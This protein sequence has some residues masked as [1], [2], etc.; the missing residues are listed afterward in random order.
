[1]VKKSI[2]FILLGFLTQFAVAETELEIGGS[3]RARW[4]FKDNI[5]DSNKNT[6]DRSDF[7][8][9]RFRLDFNAKVNS[10]VSVFIQPQFTKNFGSSEP[11][12]GGR[13][14]GGL[15]D[16]RFDVHQAKI[17]YTFHDSWNLWL[18][19]QEFAYGNHLVVGN[20]GWH[21]VGR[22]FDAIRLRKNYSDKKGWTDIF[23]SQIE[24]K[25]G[26]TFTAD[27]EFYGLYTHLK[28]LG[29]LAETEIYVFYS[30]D[31]GNASPLPKAFMTYGARLKA[32][33]GGLDVG[34]EGTGQSEYDSNQIDFELGYK[35]NTIRLFAGYATAHKD[36]QQ[37]YPTAH[38]FLGTADLFGRRNI[39]A[40]RGGLKAQ[41]G[42]DMWAKLQYNSF[43]RNDDKAPIYALSGGVFAGSTGAE[44]GSHMADELDLHWEWKFVEG[45]HLVI[46][47]SWV[48]VGEYIKNVRGKDD[49][50]FFTYIQTGT[51]F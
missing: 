47:G 10:N 7:I 16:T 38:K 45:A 48:Q 41:F 11:T 49:E 39:N 21:N 19:R 26:T 50:G 46:G 35:F 4:E 34:L 6:D 32:I 8:G 25:D 17:M 13:A 18:G 42:K 23:W 27:D 28:D 14:S 24:E 37:L 33:F 29:P 9:T 2:L 20:V 12:T 40:I 30:E 1:M 51:T 22:S 3:G 43:S 44:S 5:A 15:Q 31:D 36:Y